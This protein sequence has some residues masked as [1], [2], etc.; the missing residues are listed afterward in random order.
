MKLLKDN[1]IGI[2]LISRYNSKRL[3]NKASLKVKKFNLVEI[4]II[5]ILTLINSENVVICSSKTNNK[6]TFYKKISKKFK[7]K[8][9]FG[10]EKNVL[11]RMIDCADKFK[12]KHLVRITGDN[13]LTN[14]QSI[15]PMCKSH[16][17]NNCDYTFTESLPRGTR[18]E[19]FSLKAL[20]RH[21]KKIIDLNSTEYL[22]FFFKRSDI[23]KINKVN[24]KKIL[25]DQQML[26]ISIDTK[27]DFDDY[28][29]FYLSS[30]IK[31]LDNNKL[32][33]FLK[34]E[35][36]YRIYSNKINMV[37][38]EYDVRYTF[39]KKAKKNILKLN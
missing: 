8:L 9:F 20:K 17:V 29:K 3:K 38:K 28:K 24:F 36:R 1:N 27:R 31:R 16:I 34:K 12:F 10:S 19:I 26:S 21:Y 32:F 22:T 30:D 18:V 35:N 4:L 2:F 5:R 15:L 14:V 23:Y 25:K 13:P 37:T 7:T 39:D 6:L 11:G 33:L